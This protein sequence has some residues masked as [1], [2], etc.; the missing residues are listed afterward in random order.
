[1]P[2]TPTLRQAAVLRL[3]RIGM[4]TKEIAAEL[5]ISESAVN[6]HI[7]ALLSIYRAK[8]RTHLVHLAAESSDAS[9]DIT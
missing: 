7:S 4:T 2:R 3:L 8:S 1:M 6:K 5:S 9:V